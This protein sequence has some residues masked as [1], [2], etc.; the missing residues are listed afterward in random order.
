M[1]ASAM[2]RL[3]LPFGAT[4]SSTRMVSSGSMILILL[5]TSPPEGI[6]H[7]EHVYFKM[8][9]CDSAKLS[10]RKFSRRGE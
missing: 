9:V 1:T 6:I 4:R 7:T 2:S 10:G 5:D 3:R 8:K